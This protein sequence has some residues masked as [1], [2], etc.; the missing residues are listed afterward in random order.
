M[1][2]IIFF[3]SIF[4]FFV[5]FLFSIV[6]NILFFCLYYYFLFIE[7][8]EKERITQ[9]TMSLTISENVT[10]AVI[11]C[12]ERLG[13]EIA[14]LNRKLTHEDTRQKDYL[15]QIQELNSKLKDIGTNV[16][17]ET[18]IEMKEL[19][20]TLETKEK[21]FKENASKHI[22]QKK[23]LVARV[24][25]VEKAFTSFKQKSREQITSLTDN[26][27]EQTKQLSTR[28]EE[29]ERYR[30]E[31][32]T[33][34]TTHEEYIEK[35]KKSRKNELEESMMKVENKYEMELETIKTKLE[36]TT[37]MEEGYKTERDEFNAEVQELRLSHREHHDTI[38]QH[39]DDSENTI[40]ECASQ[41][42][43]T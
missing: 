32:E 6:T 42:L 43:G 20:D 19:N 35:E 25:G 14:I 37:R 33:L 28:I 21:E 22:S 3:F 16:R 11:E 12:E 8:E 23:K 7:I 1:L 2:F 38:Q 34:T 36:D 24:G 10:K 40:K 4:V 5:F 18:E 9:Q 29:C 30:L 41:I 27:G 31:V 17:M 15:L 13:G 39:R 26:V